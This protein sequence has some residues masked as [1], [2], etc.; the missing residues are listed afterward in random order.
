MPIMNHFYL[1]NKDFGALSQQEYLLTN[2]IGGYASGTLSGANTRRYHGLLIAAF[3]PPVKRMVLVSKVEE[4]IFRA[5]DTGIDLSANQYP[6]LVHPQGYQYLEHFTRRPVPKWDYRSGACQLRKSIFMVAG[7]NTTVL[8]YEN[9]GKYDYTLSLRPLLVYRDYHSLFHQDSQFDFYL[10][11]KDNCLKVYAKY[12]AAPLF[13]SFSKGAFIEDRNWYYNFQLPRERERG[14][15][16]QEDAYQLGK[17]ECALPPGESL[18]LTF[19]TQEPVAKTDVLAAEK[20][21]DAREARPADAITNFFEDLSWVADQFLVFRQS[22][23]GSSIIAGYHWFTDWGRD[24]MIA[25]RGLC[26]TLKKPEL[27]QSIIRSFLQ[28]LDGGLLPNNFPDGGEKPGYNSMDATL[29]LF[30]V[31]WEYQQ[32]FKDQV[33]IEEVFASLT[34]I[35]DALKKGTRYQINMTDEGLLYGG[36]AGIQLTWMDAKVDGQVITPR[37]GCP[38]E[39]NALWYNALMIYSRFAQ[40]LKK[41]ATP[42]RRL[43][44]KTKESFNRYFWNEQ[45]SCLYDVVIPNEYADPAIRPNQ[46]YALSLPF[47]LLTKGRAKQVMGVID[48]QLLTPYGLRS[49]TPKDP[50]FVG[51]YTGNRWLRDH[52]YHQGTVWTFLMGEYLLAYRY[53]HGDGTQTQTYIKKLLAPLITH[54]YEEDG[55]YALS[56]IFD[57]ATPHSG[58]GC[59]QQ[60][61]SVGMLLRG[62]EGLKNVCK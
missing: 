1:K 50:Q 36:E 25:M 51:T 35:L 16:D 18:Y 7:A 19:S 45:E 5:G 10:E 58:K 42:T 9:T 4:S 26:V 31:L 56:E 11:Q 30:V 40:D 47:L 48:K 55:L 2:G 21:P 44:E 43:A 13:L 52:A 49:L 38:V 32:K 61:W 39:I 60:A 33:F 14:L 23:N 8:K 22:T 12:G 53:L 20:L 15:D 54:F 59:I 41:E 62:L 46:I 34:T 28:Y 29:W 37:L 6:G 27:A 24:T 17:I 57:G 3:Q